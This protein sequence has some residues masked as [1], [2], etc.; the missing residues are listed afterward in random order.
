MLRGQTARS[1]CIVL[2]V[3]GM[4][5]FI[6]FRATHGGA[7]SDADNRTV[8]ELIEA[9]RDRSSEVRAEA[10]TGLMR[11]GPEAIH[12][13]APLL[14]ALGDSSAVVRANAAAALGRLGPRAED[15]LIRGLGD[16]DPQTRRGAAIALRVNGQ[17]MAAVPA[18]ARH[19]GDEDPGVRLNAARMLSRIGPCAE[20]YLLNAL[21][22]GSPAAREAAADALS[23]AEWVSAAAIPT[24]L[25]S[26][27]EP[28]EPV[29]EYV[30]K[31]FKTVGPNAVPDLVAK[32][33]STDPRV[34]RRAACAL[35]K[36]GPPSAVALGP[37]TR[38]LNDYDCLV[39]ASAAEALGRIGCPSAAA[40]A[41]LQSRVN[42]CE[43]LVRR[44][45]REALLQLDP[46]HAPPPPRRAPPLPEPVPVIQ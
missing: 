42:D 15:A 6:T 29:G 9:L 41:G 21:A 2:S 36:L 23:E 33:S 22:S 25:I 24:L 10:A 20:P 12:A 16:S 32:I 31:A 39:R 8:E 19:L 34:R 13:L 7:E 5:A 37:L 27:G 1:A 17:A 18:L 46:E 11:H 4:A 14:T 45:V 3:I 35:G 43:P 30:V 44:A 38:A 26:L 28:E 40:I